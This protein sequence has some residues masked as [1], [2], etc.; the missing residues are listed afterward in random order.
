MVVR[1]VARALQK[2]MGSK[3]Q[4]IRFIQ[5]CGLRAGEPRVP[6]DLE[7]PRTRLAQYI[8]RWLSVVGHYDR[9][10]GTWERLPPAVAAFKQNM[11]DELMALMG[12]SQD[13]I[14]R[15]RIRAHNVDDANAELDMVFAGYGEIFET[16]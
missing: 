16:T 10:S 3:V 6:C 9:E 14:V 2:S 11:L 15:V 8:D 7:L 13:E 1:R 5:C 4:A 12:M